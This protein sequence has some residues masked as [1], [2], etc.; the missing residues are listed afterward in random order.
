MTPTVIAK[1]ARNLL[2]TLEI[3]LNRR[4][5]REFAVKASLDVPTGGRA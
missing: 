4:L 3:K 5:L 1:S 2:S